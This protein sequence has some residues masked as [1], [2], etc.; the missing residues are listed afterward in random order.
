MCTLPSTCFLH[1]PRKSDARCCCRTEHQVLNKRSVRLRVGRN[2][3]GKIILLCL[4]G[5]VKDKMQNPGQS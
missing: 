2:V 4:C 5:T 3:F 1:E